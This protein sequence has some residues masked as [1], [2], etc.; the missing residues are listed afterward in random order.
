[1][2]AITPSSSRL[3][4]AVTYMTDSPP[5]ITRMRDARPQGHV[6]SR[7]GLRRPLSS[8]GRIPSLDGLRCVAIVLVILGHVWAGAELDPGYLGSLANS[9]ASHGVAVFFVISGFLITRLLMK[10]RRAT[11]RI[12]VGRFYLRRTLR[13]WPALWV[14]LLV[15][16]LL[17]AAQVVSLSASEVVVA[18]LFLTDY[19]EGPVEGLLHHTWSLAV[20]EQ[21]Y[22]VWPLV[23]VA[24]SERSA[25]R[26][27]ALLIL[28]APAIR[29]VTYLVMPDG[30]QAV[31]FHTRYDSLAFGCL[32]ALVWDAPRFKTL[33]ARLTRWR[34]VVWAI[35][36]EV[37]VV[38]AAATPV[39]SQFMSLVGYSVENA[40]VA[41]VVGYCILS[42][43]RALNMRS[44]MW[45]G[46]LSYSLYLWQQ[47]F[48]VGRPGIFSNP[49]LALGG[50]IA[51]ACVSYYAVEKPIQ[52]LRSRLRP[53]MPARMPASLIE[54]PVHADGTL[55]RDRQR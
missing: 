12:A 14:L 40:A 13:L 2:R 45:V 46:S 30:S 41:Y 22:L 47:L 21:F 44:M 35:A 31:M 16:S 8:E 51:A 27:T 26:L 1:V 29:V 38:L 53:D 9:T 5:T 20:E 36:A 49:W 43:P 54:G 33:M 6:A 3:L 39:G 7:S 52:R 19:H 18:A 17:G 32:L 50:T 28:V 4:T 55:T 25:R 11:G 15:T 23:F 34:F 42:A 48:L 10:E 37:G 24:L